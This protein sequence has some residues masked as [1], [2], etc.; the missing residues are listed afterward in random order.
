M[1]QNQDKQRGRGRPSVAVKHT[2]CAFTFTIPKETIGALLA[3][4]IT[5]DKAKKLAS[6]AAFAALNILLKQQQKQDEQ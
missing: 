2:P 3:S 5:E 1:S 4:G 6:T